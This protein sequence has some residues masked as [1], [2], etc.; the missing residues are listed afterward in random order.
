[1]LDDAGHD[2]AGGLGRRQLDLRLRSGLNQ[3]RRQGPEFAGQLLHHLP[4]AVVRFPH[5]MVVTTTV[6]SG[7]IDDQ[8][9]QA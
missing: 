7:V 3:Y 8:V 6:G 9:Q 1:M 2:A 5:V 4:S